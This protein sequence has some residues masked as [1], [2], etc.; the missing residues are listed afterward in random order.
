VSTSSCEVQYGCQVSQVNP[1][2]CPK[3]P[4]A[5]DSGLT[6]DIPDSPENSCVPDGHDPLLDTEDG[7]LPDDAAGV[8]DATVDRDSLSGGIQPGQTG[9]VIQRVN[10]KS[11]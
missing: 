5:G 4:G 1:S 3:A 7:R 2:P 11:F 10:A 9:T 6:V 8:G